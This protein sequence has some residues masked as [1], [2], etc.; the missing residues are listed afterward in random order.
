[1]RAKLII[2][3]GRRMAAVG[4]ADAGA[5]DQMLVAAIDHVASEASPEQGDVGAAAVIRMDA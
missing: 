4:H 2:Q 1:M 5:A 3:A